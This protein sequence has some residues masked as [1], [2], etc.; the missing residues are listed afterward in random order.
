MLFIQRR[1]KRTKEVKTVDTADRKK[2]A[3][4]KIG[5]LRSFDKDGDFFTSKKPAKNWA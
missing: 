4:E 5:N 2:D 1:D 3:E